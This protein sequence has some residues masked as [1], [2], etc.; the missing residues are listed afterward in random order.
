M[1]ILA[2]PFGG[3]VPAVDAER[4]QRFDAFVR[5][6]RDRAIALAWR[7]VGGDGS[8]AEDVAQEA[9]VRAHRSLDRFRGDA[10]LSTWFTRILLNEAHRHLRWR[11][12]RERW[13]AEMP[14][15]PAAPAEPMGDP[16]LRA[17]IGA[18]LATLPRG[19]REAFVLVHLEGYTV[20]ETAEITGRAAGTIKS[21][22]H[23]ALK[24][25]RRELGD[26]APE[27]Q[28]LAE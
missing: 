22:L 15:E 26:L 2:E 21:H 19:Q 10:Q 6:H 20:R 27:G 1:R 24:S 13:A 28:A 23:R 16:G 5:D 7:M 17:R 3:P 8:A 12:V 11:W 14:E 9:F 4:Q 25:L 18:A